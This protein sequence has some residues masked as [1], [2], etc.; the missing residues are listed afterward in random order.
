MI[1]A[2]NLWTNRRWAGW[3]AAVC[4]CLAFAGCGKPLT[5]QDLTL[6]KS[7][8]KQSLTTALDA[9]KAGKQPA[10]LKEGQPSITV[11]DLNWSSGAKLADYKI[12][13]E[14]EAGVNLIIQV[15]L[16]LDKEGEPTTRKLDYTIGTSPVIAVIANEEQD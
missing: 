8:A 1:A 15:E 11:A 13:A 6:D 5:S 12:L 16:T 9:W 4:L 3:P 7:L 2:R 10:A 14:R